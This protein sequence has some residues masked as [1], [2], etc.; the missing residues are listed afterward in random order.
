ME[1]AVLI[2]L[3]VCI[4]SDFVASLPLAWPCTC[5]AELRVYQPADWLGRY[6]RRTLTGTGSEH[7]L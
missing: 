7:A 5:V 2:T 3:D 4:E 1:I 6:L